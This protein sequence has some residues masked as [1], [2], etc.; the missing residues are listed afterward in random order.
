MA[1]VCADMLLDIY[2]LVSTL[3]DVVKFATW[4]WELL[5]ALIEFSMPTKMPEIQ[6]K[7]KT[8]TDQFWLK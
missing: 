8:L 6:I 2:E 5:E 3:W 1:A 7:L 4:F